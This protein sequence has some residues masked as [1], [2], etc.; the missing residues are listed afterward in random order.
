M[1]SIRIDNKSGEE[2]SDEVADFVMTEV[3]LVLLKALS[4]MSQK[5]DFVTEIVVTEREKAR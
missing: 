4:K 3:R 2:I 5:Q 1:L